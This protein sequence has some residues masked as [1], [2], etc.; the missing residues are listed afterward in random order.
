[1]RF[2]F[3]F[4]FEIFSLIS[5]SQ[6][7][8]SNRDSCNYYFLSNWFQRVD[9]SLSVQYRYSDSLWFILESFI[10]EESEF[11]IQFIEYEKDFIVGLWSPYSMA[12]LSV[13]DLYLIVY[14]PSS[15]KFIFLSSFD[16]QPLSCLKNLKITDFFYR[17]KICF[18]VDYCYNYISFYMLNLEL[19]GAKTPYNHVE[20]SL[21]GNILYSGF[22]KKLEEYSQKQYILTNYSNFKA[23]SNRLLESPIDSLSLKSIYDPSRACAS[24]K[25]CFSKIS[26]TGASFPAKE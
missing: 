7:S 17:F 18:I 9:T 23:F 20:Y 21:D 15:N 4:L 14:I 25:E 13:V 12:D 24:Y 8:T 19:A 1:M 3:V 6:N 10:I 2:V 16:D 11:R 5:F 26:P 22:S